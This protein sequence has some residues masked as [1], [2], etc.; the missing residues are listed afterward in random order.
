MY[1]KTVA[2]LSAGLQAGQFSSVELTRSFLA[3][4]AA[5]DGVYNSF[6]SVAGEQALAAAAAADERIAAGTAGPLTGIPLAHKDIF[7]TDGLRTSCGSRM[8]DNFVPPY[9]ATLI[10]RFKRDGAVT[11][12]R[13]RRRDAAGR[14]RDGAAVRQARGR[15][16]GPPARLNL[17]ARRVVGARPAAPPHA[18]AE[19]GRG[20]G[21]KHRPGDDQPVQQ[22]PQRDIGSHP[23]NHHELGDQRDARPFR[24]QVRLGAQ[25]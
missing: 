12:G 24:K 19:R 18:V 22:R 23:A 4:I 3:R 14:P 9:D 8:L 5:L 2:Q 17:T 13:E 25:V 1:D 7:C 11:L 15:D 6:I 20:M 10:S 21:K 16:H